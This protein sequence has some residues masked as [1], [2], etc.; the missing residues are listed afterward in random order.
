MSDNRLLLV[1]PR[2]MSKVLQDLLTGLIYYQAKYAKTGTGKR[3]V[4]EN[5]NCNVK[6]CHIQTPSIL[7]T[8]P[9]FI[10]LQQTHKGSSV[11]TDFWFPSPLGLYSSKNY[12]D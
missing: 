12:K 8:T 2:D 10:L 9:Q 5:V 11:K 7:G 3:T 6:L 1:N 4:K